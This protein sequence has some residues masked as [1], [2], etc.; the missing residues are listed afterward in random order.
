MGSGRSIPAPSPDAY[1]ASWLSSKGFESSSSVQSDGRT[2]LHAA[3]RSGDEW[4]CRYLLLQPDGEA[5]LL[6]RNKLGETP[7]KLALSSGHLTVCDFL[8]EACYDAS[9][10]EL[11][12]DG[13]VGCL[14][15]SMHGECTISM[16]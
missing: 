2:A 10:P 8:F 1:A 16:F 11:A 5:Q 15:A 9:R 12:F 14:G 13:D 3:A 6:A 4:M 7:L